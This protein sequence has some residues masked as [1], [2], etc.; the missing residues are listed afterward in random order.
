MNANELND[1]LRENAVTIEVDNTFSYDA[2]K[3]TCVL[4]GVGVTRLIGCTANGKSIGYNITI[5]GEPHFLREWRI[6]KYEY[7]F[8]W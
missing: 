7:K 3:D 6:G 2:F 1:F 8:V 5:N 4:L